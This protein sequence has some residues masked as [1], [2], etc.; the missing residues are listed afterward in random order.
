MGANKIGAM[1]AKVSHITLGVE[2]IGRATNFYTSLGFSILN[3][4]GD[5]FVV[6]DTDGTKVA[7]FPYRKLAEDAGKET[8]HGN[9]SGIT[10]GHNVASK[11]KVDEVLGEVANLGAKIIRPAQ[12]T[13]WRGYS[14]YFEDLDGHVW[15]VAWNPF[16]NL[17]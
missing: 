3:G 7:L 13:F 9:F 6:F 14:G 12:D 2:D 16:T 10:L 5:D 1:K 4:D 17:T 15:E 11:E 8:G